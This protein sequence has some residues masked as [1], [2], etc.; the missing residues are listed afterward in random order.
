M[1]MLMMLGALLGAFPIASAQP[2]TEPIVR[3]PL[4]Q[5]GR[6]IAAKVEIGGR[7]R[8][9]Q[10]D[11]AGGMTVVT[12]ATAK[13]IGCVPW[14]RIVG[15]HMRGARIS[16]SRC[17]DVRL[18]WHG[19][20]LRAPA[21]L[22]LDVGSPDGSLALDAFAGRTVTVDFARMEL[23]VE[24]VTSA[25]ERVR[26]AT[27]IK[28]HLAREVG[29][30]ALSVFVDL[31]ARHGPLRLELDSGNTGPN[32]LS[33]PL[34]AYVGLDPAATGG[35]V[36][37]LRL[38]DGVAVTGPIYSPDLVIDGNLGM[39]FLKDWVVTLNLAAGRVWLR[40][41][42]V[43][44]PRGLGDLPPPPPATPRPADASTPH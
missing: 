32:L 23:T 16:G 3:L 18:R 8:L 27:E 43:L 44:P 41:S 25:A 21:A 22:V 9:F 13:A 2:G 12:P 20:D 30:L 29:G 33:R 15:F 6:G 40:A 38:T 10:V 31:P 19:Y 7:E 42:S 24:S 39:S 34:L 35:Q 37:S 11:T 36:T 1:K 28:A 14:G 26:G 17:D 4:V 5:Y